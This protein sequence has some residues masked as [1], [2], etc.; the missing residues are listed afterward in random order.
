MRA[1]M[2]Y[3]PVTISPSAT[4]Q[5]AA[6]RMLEHQVSGLPVVRGNQLV[7]ILTESDIFRLVVE[8]WA[9]E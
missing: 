2:T 5:E 7:G 4:I 6:E 1:V 8:S 9:E 3:S